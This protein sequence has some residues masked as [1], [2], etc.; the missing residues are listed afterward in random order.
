MTALLLE[1]I[2]LVMLFVLISSILTLSRLG[3]LKAGPTRS[4]GRLGHHRAAS[5]RF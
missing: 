3:G 1:N 2:K 4:K 5:A